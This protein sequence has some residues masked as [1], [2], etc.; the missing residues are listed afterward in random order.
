MNK[1]EKRILERLF[2]RSLEDIEHLSEFARSKTEKTLANRL[3]KLF[4]KKQRNFKMS[5]WLAEPCSFPEC[6]ETTTIKAFSLNHAIEK[7]LKKQINPVFRRFCEIE[8][9][10]ITYTKRYDYSEFSE[11]CMTESFVVEDLEEIK[12]YERQLR[13][14]TL[15]LKLEK[16]HI[17]E[18]GNHITLVHRTNRKHPYYCRLYK[19]LH[20]NATPIIRN[21]KN[22]NPIVRGDK[23][24]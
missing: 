12:E 11:N 17:Q 23:P 3:L 4:Y 9:D 21:I 8:N 7:T 19:I 20:K 14:S 13:H 18:S 16:T 2:K 5:Y 15:E 24:Q 6:R 1:T 10:T 22:K